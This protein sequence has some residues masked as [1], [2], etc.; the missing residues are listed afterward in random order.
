MNPIKPTQK[1]K[2]E[3]PPD[4]EATPKAK[5]KFL[6]RLQ[7]YGVPL[8]LVVVAS[9]Q[10]YR[11]HADGL[12]SWRGGGFG[13]YGGYHPTQ[14]DLWWTSTETGESVRYT[15]KKGVATE[16]DRYRSLRPFL[17]YVN[18]PSLSR[19]FSNLPREVQET[20]R[21]EIWQLD[22]DPTTG[23]LGRRLLLSE[24]TEETKGVE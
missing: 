3:E 6:T 14:N 24:G 8:L 10:F 16:D 2:T 13:M 22:F 15:K 9:H 17:T 4:R 5:S 18:G 20:T 12:S 23:I 7:H 19:Y 11:V 1:M 21:V